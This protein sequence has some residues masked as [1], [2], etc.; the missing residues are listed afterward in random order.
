M[1][2]LLYKSKSVDSDYGFFHM[3]YADVGSMEV[4]FVLVPF[5]SS[6]SDNEV[7]VLS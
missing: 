4:S 7:C 1:A 6:C 5:L 2:C 3:L